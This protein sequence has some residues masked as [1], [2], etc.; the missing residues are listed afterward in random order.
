MHEY[1]QSIGV[2]TSLHYEIRA[3][4]YNWLDCSILLL[5]LGVNPSS[6]LTVP[7]EHYFMSLPAAT[8]ATH[9]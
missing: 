7:V 1:W 2:I 9:L 6:S 4:I 5:F 3:T 8:Y